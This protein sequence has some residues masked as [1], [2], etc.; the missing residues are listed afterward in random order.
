MIYDVM[1]ICGKG[2]G[3]PTGLWV[4][5]IYARNSVTGEM[6][7]FA[8][9]RVPGKTREEAEEFCNTNGLGYCKVVDRFVMEITVYYN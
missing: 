7:Y 5:E 8:G 3:R 6:A 4:T 2:I 1:D 9:P